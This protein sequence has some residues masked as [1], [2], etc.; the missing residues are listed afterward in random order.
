MS[1][2][3]S[4][5]NQLPD[6]IKVLKGILKDECAHVSQVIKS[7]L[8]LADMSELDLLQK[9]LGQLSHR[10]NE[11]EARVSDIEAIV[12]KNEQSQ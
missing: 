8:G 9:Q 7:D 11:L 12:K 6:E 1:S 10:V 2:L 5:L 3:S 4:L